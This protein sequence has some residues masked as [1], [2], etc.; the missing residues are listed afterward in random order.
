[1]KGAI[2]LTTNFSEE[3][4]FAYG[5]PHYTGVQFKSF[6]AWATAHEIFHLLIGD[7]HFNGINNL[8]GDR[9]AVENAVVLPAELLQM[10]LKTRRGVTQ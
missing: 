4:P 10:N 7:W 9:V 8:M 6:L 1:M 2:I 3:A 5:E